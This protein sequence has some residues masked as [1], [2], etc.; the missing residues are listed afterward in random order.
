MSSGI[1]ISLPPRRTSLIKANILI[2]QAC[3]ARLADFG[4]LTMA[5]DTTSNS[6]LEGSTWRWM[7]P[8]F[9]NPEKFNL[10]DSRQTKYSDCYALGMVVYEVMSGRLPFCRHHVLPI[11]G[12]II[13]GKRPGRPRGQE[14]RWFTDD[15]WGML[16]R[17]WKP[18]PCDRPN[19]KDVLQCLEEA[20][21]SWAPSSPH[22]TPT[23][24]ITNPTIWTSDTSTEENTDKSEAPSPS[25]TVPSQSPQ[26]L[27]LKGDPNEISTYPFAMDF[28]LYPVLLQITR[29]SR[30]VWR[31]LTDQT[32]NL[33]G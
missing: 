2:Y 12:K 5:S 11:I 26:E 20:S 17:W 28:Q 29:A 4:L 13:D 6:F 21:R 23:P 10:K 19:I 22:P 15:V 16:E 25:R 14:G 8:E 30:R 33:Q 1:Y 9:F 32:R 31:I 3:R 24:L 27:P 18:S 7:S